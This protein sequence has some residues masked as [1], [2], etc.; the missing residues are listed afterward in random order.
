MEQSRQD[1][2]AA[3]TNY[4][5]IAPPKG[6]RRET[7][8]LAYAYFEQMKTAKPLSSDILN[9]LLSAGTSAERPLHKTPGA[10]ITRNW[11]GCDYVVEV[12]KNGYIFDGKTFGSLS[13]IA[14]VITGT[15][16]SGPR[17]FKVA[18]K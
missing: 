8:S 5:G 14:K 6:M 12:L 15:H 3:W 16:W 17:F 7:L 2:I 9:M 1:L 10:K 4:Y 13:E 18:K 11:R